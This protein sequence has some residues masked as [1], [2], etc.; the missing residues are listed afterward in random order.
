MAAGEECRDLCNALEN[1]GQFG[2]VELSG[3]TYEQLAFGNKY[4]SLMKREAFF[5]EFV[6][7]IVRS[8]QKTKAYVTGSLRTVGTMVE[9]LKTV[10]GVGF[11]RPMCQE[12]HFCKDIL[13]GKITG[14]INQKLDQN[15]FGLT[16][17]AAGTQS[18]QVGNDEE[19]IDLSKEENA[20]AFLK[21]METWGQKMHRDAVSMNMYGYVDIQSVKTQHYGTV[22]A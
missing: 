13:D 9:A 12:F 2:F 19:Q 8:L 4:E 5:L 11:A 3:C 14:A 1:E 15:N 18:R 21:D 22:E 7:A 17:V 20:E 10:D 6:E 16:N